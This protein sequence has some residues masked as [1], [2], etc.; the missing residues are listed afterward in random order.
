[1]HNL[2]KNGYNVIVVWEQRF[3]LNKNKTAATVIEQ[4]KEIQNDRFFTDSRTRIV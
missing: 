3:K 1:M 2:N 4:I